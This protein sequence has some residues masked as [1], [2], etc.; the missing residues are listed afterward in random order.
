MNG[1]V[2]IAP[3]DAISD[4]PTLVEYNGYRLAIYQTEQ[5]FRAIDDICPHMGASI[6]NGTREQDVAVC[7]WH[8]WRFD[9]DTG[10]CL[11]NPQAVL[12]VFSPVVSDGW[13]WLPEPPQDDLDLDAW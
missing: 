4:R 1:Y 10:A 9:L 2:K 12:T 11:N 6:S 3:L 7:P 13:L 8:H 5:G